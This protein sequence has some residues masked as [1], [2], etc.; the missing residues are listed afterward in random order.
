MHP[1]RKVLSR[2]EFQQ[3]LD[4]LGLAAWHG[5]GRTFT[6]SQAERACE[7][8]GLSEQLSTFK[9]GARA[10]AISLLAVFYFRQARKIEG[11]RTFEFTH[12]SFREYLTARRLARWIEDIH[13]ER[14]RNR[15]NR[16]RGWS[17]EVAL[18]KWIELTGPTSF[19]ED[20]LMFVIRELASSRRE[21]VAEWQ[22]TFADLLSGALSHGLPMH[23]LQL[24]T[25]LEMTYQARN[26]EEAL[27]ATLHACAEHTEIWSE[28]SWPSSGALGALIKRVQSEYD[29]E[30]T[31]VLFVNLCLSRLNMTGQTCFNADLAQAHLVSAKLDDATLAQAL[32]WMANL[33]RASLVGANIFYANLY[34]ANLTETNLEGANLEGANL[35]GAK[36]ERKWVERLGLDA[37]KLRLE[38]VDDVAD[39]QRPLPSEA[40][41]QVG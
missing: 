9:E 31:S 10:G 24:P 23:R 20:L 38:V 28:V 37:K 5:T 36:I 34:Y 40:E 11:E 13:E 26:A 27:L 19:D 32:L 39:D 25:F 8:A 14:Q 18:I 22:K 12:K 15:N 6:E 4:E 29:L 3:L 1:T 41:S 30:G 35:R 16:Q 2:D 17:E 21:T 7:K 33:T